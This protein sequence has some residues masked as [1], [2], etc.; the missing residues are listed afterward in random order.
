M[1]EVRKAYNYYKKQLELE[2]PI[3]FSKYKD[4]F[5]EYER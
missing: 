2:H 1:S 4:L 5:D 3:L